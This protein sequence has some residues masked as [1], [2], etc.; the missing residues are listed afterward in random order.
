MASVFVVLSHVSLPVPRKVF[1]IFSSLYPADTKICGND[2][3]TCSAG[4]VDVLQLIG[5]LYNT[6][7]NL[8]KMV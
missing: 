5:S 2:S 1:F 6:F 8:Q 4:L 7:V 3:D